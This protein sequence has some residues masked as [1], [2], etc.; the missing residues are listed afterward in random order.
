[1][2]QPSAH[3]DKKRTSVTG[4]THLSI[5]AIAATP[6]VELFA[7]YYS[8]FDHSILLDF[9]CVARCV[10]GTCVDDVFEYTL[11]QRFAL[12]CCSMTCP[13]NFKMKSNSER[14]VLLQ[15][16]MRPSH[17]YKY[18]WNSTSMFFRYLQQNIFNSFRC[19]TIG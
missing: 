3:R 17:F 14:A 8:K 2:Y 16:K 19:A 6:F 18:F 15:K 12:C 1:M 5:L 13:A 9:G 11:Q 4:N 7:E 10:V